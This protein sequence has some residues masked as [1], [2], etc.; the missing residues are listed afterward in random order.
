MLE[1]FT[2]CLE[3]KRLYVVHYRLFLFSGMMVVSD[4]SIPFLNNCITNISLIK[5][6]SS[7]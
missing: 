2:S 5:P 4:D 1:W 3:K 6:S 7:V